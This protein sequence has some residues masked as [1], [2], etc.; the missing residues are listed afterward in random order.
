[1][2]EPGSIDPGALLART[3]RLDD[4]F[5]VRLRLARRTDAAA[6][7]ALLERCGVEVTELEISRL[8]RPDPRREVT[9]CAAAPVD[10]QEEV[11]GVGSISYDDPDATRIIACDERMRAGGVQ[12]LDAA[13][14]EL[15]RRR[16]R[17]VA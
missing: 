2:P 4:G 12:L 17:R 9:I 8:V 16:A 13:L 11:V 3:W 6:V 5:R 14:R 7:G 1:V 10:G 15:I